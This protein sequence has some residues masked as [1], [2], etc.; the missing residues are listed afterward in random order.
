MM[1][2]ARACAPEIENDPEG[3]QALVEEMRKAR[4]ALQVIKREAP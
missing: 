2:H 1:R 4:A 3:V